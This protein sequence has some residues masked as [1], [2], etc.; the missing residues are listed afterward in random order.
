MSEFA[1]T[2]GQRRRLQRQRNAAQDARVYRRTLALLEV[3]RGT[4]IAQLAETLGVTRQS[5]YNW[6]EDYTQAHD[7]ADLYDQDRSGRPRSWTEK[8]L[9]RLRSLLKGPPNRL[10]YFAVN[11]TV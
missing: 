10:G 9:G 5:I 7:P 6:I 11:W 2:S 4:P 1:L 8:L 3:E